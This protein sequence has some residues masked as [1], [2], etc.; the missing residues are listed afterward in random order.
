MELRDDPSL[1]D[2]ALREGG[3]GV[4]AA[5]EERRPAVGAGVPATEATLA[6]LGPAPRE[7]TRGLEPGTVVGRHVVLHRLG[8][9]RRAARIGAWIAGALA[10]V[11]AIV[12]LELGAIVTFVLTPGAA[13]ADEA[14]PPAPDYAD[15][16]SWSALP[17]RDDPADRSP[18]D[19]PGVDPASAKVDVF[20]VH[21][22]SYVGNRWN[23]PTNDAGINEGTD[24]VGT[25]IQ[26]AAFGGC[27]A[28]HAPR[29]RQANLTAFY[30][31]SEDGD[32]A[33]D[34][35]YED[36]RRAFAAFRARVGPERPFILAA[37]SQGSVMAERLLYEVIS[38]SDLRDR[39]VAAYLVGA[40]VTEAG[41]RER[42]PDVPPCRASDDVRCVVAWNARAPGYEPTEFEM[43]RA[44]P[45]ELLCTNPLSWRTDD[46]HAPAELN[47]GAVFLETDDHAPRVGFADARCVG[48]RLVV[49]R[50][51]DV[52]RDLPSRVLDRAMGHGNYHPI[53][54]QIF[55]MSLRQN[56]ADRVAAFLAANG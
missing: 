38:G 41:L 48:G 4:D 32:R 37:H 35:A 9:W 21:S 49:E 22:S 55:F 18:D 24:R 50:I 1:P 54:Y 7:P 2:D 44:D 20:F 15:P 43:Y 30:R 33:I 46:V 25:G 11:V 17:E 6:G 26:A 39:L 3:T 53:E 40:R 16:S 56:A 23:A 28:I 47:L 14:P 8:R 52:P 19:A 10:V 51:G 31:P 13:F 34:L 36:V 29:Y 12:V 42:A 45:R 27:C 5:A